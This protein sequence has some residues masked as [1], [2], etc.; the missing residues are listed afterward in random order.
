MRRKKRRQGFFEPSLVPMADMLCN[1]VGITVFLLIFTVLTAG[2]SVTPKRLPYEHAPKANDVSDFVCF[3]NRVLPL[4]VATLERRFAKVVHRPSE[5]T[6]DNIDGFL[7][8]LNAASVQ[9]KYFTLSMNGQLVNANGGE[10]L[11]TSTL[12]QAKGNVGDPIPS[13]T[14]ND[15]LFKS[16]LNGSNPKEKFVFFFVYPDSI[17]AFEA[18]RD[19]A[20]QMHFETGWGDLPQG[21]PLTFGSGGRAMGAQ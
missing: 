7:Q 21:Q 14:K 2:A 20:N 6:F 15:S 13:L 4:D 10:A 16:Q 1:T 3:G 17:K 8:R 9:D 5:L 12:V 19:I 11:E 18:A